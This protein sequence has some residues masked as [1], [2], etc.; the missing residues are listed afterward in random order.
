ME[1]IKSKITKVGLAAISAVIAV[2][3]V[4]SSIGV[5]AAHAAFNSNAQ[6]LAGLIAVSNLSGTSGGAFT[7]TNNLGELIVLSGLF[8]TSSNSV[9]NA[10]NLAGLIAVDAVTGGS[11]GGAFTNNGSNLADL[12]VL[13]GLFLDP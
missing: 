4:V 2:F 7:N 13:N 5:P 11:N 9:Q 12:I 3:I 10:K 6:A 8:P 1:K